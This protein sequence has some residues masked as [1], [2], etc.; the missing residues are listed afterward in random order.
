MRVGG[1]F[2]GWKSETEKEHVARDEHRSVPAGLGTG[3]VAT[4]KELQ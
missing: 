4:C 1:L 3:Q 2:S